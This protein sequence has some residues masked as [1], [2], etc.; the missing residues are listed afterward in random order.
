M[1]S[2]PTYSRFRAP[3]DSSNHYAR[4]A[5]PPQRLH[6]GLHQNQCVHRRYEK[7]LSIMVSGI[8]ALIR[9]RSRCTEGWT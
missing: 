7:A 5:M 2:G 9:E 1:H 8:S 3:C 6:I 4:D